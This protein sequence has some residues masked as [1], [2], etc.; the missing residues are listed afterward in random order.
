[1]VKYYDN[2]R[3]TIKLFLF[4]G[5]NCERLND[6]WMCET[7]NNIFV[8]KLLKPIGETPVT[9]SGHTS[10]LYKNE[11][12]IFGGFIRDDS[13]SKNKEK[14]LIYE[15]RTNEY[16]YEE[17]LSK[18]VIK[19][20]RNHIAESVG[21]HM[22]V[23]GGIDDQ[24]NYLNDSWLLDFSNLRW[25]RID[26]KGI[27][28]PPLAFH[29][30]SIVISQQI[31][32]DPSFTIFRNPDTTYNK[33]Y[34]TKTKIKHE[35]IYIFGGINDEGKYQNE[36]YVIKNGRKPLERILLKISGT[37][38]A[39]RALA[40]MNFY[41]NLNIVILHGGRNDL[42]KNGVIFND[43]WLIDLENL[44]WYKLITNDGISKYVTECRAEHV[45]TII[46]NNLIIFGGSDEKHFMNSEL[47]SIHI[48]LLY[49]KLKKGNL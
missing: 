16:V 39:P 21:I 18:E 23:F 46:E 45:S 25:I 44:V 6:M 9:R 7:K 47:C 38:P 34:T 48:D 15:I 36:L 33:K 49:C 11:I 17:S 22:L 13:L 19:W 8:W 31:L 10:V 35:G 40:N 14:I 28:I 20:R 42:L 30:S 5:I 43:F 37:A 24:S 2:E 4:G 1:L 32:E 12:F 3:K 27:K 41:E 26:V 29:C